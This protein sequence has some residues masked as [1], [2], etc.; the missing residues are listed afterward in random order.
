M[1]RRA[2][3]WLMHQIWATPDESARYSAIDDEIEG[4]R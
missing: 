3:R 2:W 1:I 4:L